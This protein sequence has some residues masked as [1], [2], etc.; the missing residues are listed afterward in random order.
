PQARYF[1]VGRIGRDQAVDYA[2]RKGIEL[3][4]A[5]RWLRPNLAYEPA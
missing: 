4:E 5:E 3:A 1:S 2:R